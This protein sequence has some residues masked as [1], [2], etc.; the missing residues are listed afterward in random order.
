LLLITGTVAIFFT[1]LSNPK[2][3]GPMSLGEKLQA[4]WFHSVT[5][6]TAGFNTVDIGAMVTATLF[7]T[8][9]LMLVGGSPGGTAGGVKTTTLR[10]LTS[11]TGAILQ[12]KEKVTI[13]ER[14][15][16]F[17]LILKAVGVVVGSVAMVLISTTLIAITDPGIDFIRVLLE[18]VSAFATVGL[19]TGITAA[20][21]TPAKLVII[22]TMYVGRV[23]VLLLM[24]GVL[25]DPRPSAVRYPEE[26]MLVG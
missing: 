7:I 25:G 20:L 3:F 13:Y 18:V 21:S 6:R 19:S 23:G 14:Q 24:G 12:Q 5:T 17:S 26:N 10:V 15:V 11:C 2:T 16:P 22:A 9:A 4:A 1:E 8:I